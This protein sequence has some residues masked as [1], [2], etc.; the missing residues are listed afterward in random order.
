MNHDLMAVAASETIV[1]LL[2]LCGTAVGKGRPG[3]TGARRILPR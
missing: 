2:T 1:E 3:T